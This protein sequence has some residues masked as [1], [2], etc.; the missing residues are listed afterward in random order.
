MA[1][2]PDLSQYLKKTQQRFARPF[3]PVNAAPPSAQLAKDPWALEPVVPSG[4]SSTTASTLEGFADTVKDDSPPQ[5]N[6]SPPSFGATAIRS[7]AADGWHI[8]NASP[9]PRFNLDSMSAPGESGLGSGHRPAYNLP[10]RSTSHAY[11]TPGTRVGTASESRTNVSEVLQEDTASWWRRTSPKESDDH[12]NIRSFGSLRAEINAHPLAKRTSTTNIMGPRGGSLFAKHSAGLLPDIDDVEDGGMVEFRNEGS[13]RPSAS[14]SSDDTQGMLR[15]RDFSATPNS[16][17]MLQGDS[18]IG[19]NSGDQ[20]ALA[21]EVF[22]KTT[23]GRSGNGTARQGQEV[24]GDAGTSAHDDDRISTAQFRLLKNQVEE[25]QSQLHAAKSMLQDALSNSSVTSPKVGAPHAAG[26]LIPGS[27]GQREERTGGAANAGT[28]PRMA[29]TSLS[30]SGKSPEHQ[31]KILLAENIRLRSENTALTDRLN[32]VEQQ[33]M[34]MALEKVKVMKEQMLGAERRRID[35]EIRLIASLREELWAASKDIRRI[36]RLEAGWM[37][38]TDVEQQP[39]RTYWTN[40]AASKGVAWCLWS[41]PNEDAPGEREDAAESSSPRTR[42]H[43]NADSDDSVILPP[44]PTPRSRHVD[45]GNVSEVGPADPQGD[46]SSN[47]QRGTNSEADRDRGAGKVTGNRRAYPASPRT[48]EESVASGIPVDT[49]LDGAGSGY[50]AGYVKP[51]P[52]KA[53]R[54]SSLQGKLKSLGSL[55][56]AGVMLKKRNSN[57]EQ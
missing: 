57:V 7:S 5:H 10:S 32:S 12:N 35:T 44:P 41:V 47:L 34:G 39:P 33:S 9:V 27:P 13:S 18:P 24:R 14:V 37:Q 4:R 16:S 15:E 17:W 38:Q 51:V 21:R 8:S 52:R 48:W 31:L 50:Y 19:M 23:E 40:S 1:S 29:D 45:V 20:S 25:L 55:V 42:P 30:L 2:K 22:Q 43:A 11:S 3:K 49:D 26:E 6:E 36:R 54:K 46:R 28:P 56:K 53:E